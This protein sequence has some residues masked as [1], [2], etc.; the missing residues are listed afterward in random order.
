MTHDIGPDTPVGDV[1][2]HDERT[3]TVF[4][5][6]GIDFCCGGRQT[7][8]EAC[9]A[10]HLSAPDLI[11]E[12]RRFEAPG[13]PK[14][15]MTGWPAPKLIEWIVARHHTYV[16]AEIPAIARLLDQAG[17]RHGTDHPELLEIRA[18]FGIVAD[19]LMRHMAKEERVLFPAITWLAANE[20]EQTIGG[21]SLSVIHPIQ[22]M[23]AEHEEAA[24]QL[25]HIRALANDYLAPP[26][27]CAT[28]KSAYQLLAA[29]EGD[30][31]RHVHLENNILFPLAL[32][33]VAGH[34]A[35]ASDCCRRA[36]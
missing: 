8:A 33:L 12:L 9:A 24:L 30:L 23:E 22:A 16:R 10:H 31:K 34:T 29:F 1:V 26:D 32:D 36:S 17:A 20:A 3:A 14:D 19:D 15:D 25:Q 5:R 28:W 6:H 4:T 27:A 18:R 13:E 35:S 21:R 7:L 11:D 2:V